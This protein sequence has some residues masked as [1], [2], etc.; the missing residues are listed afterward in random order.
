MTAAE[1]ASLLAEIGLPA[2]AVALIAYVL[3]MP[4]KAQMISG[5]LWTLIAGVFRR[6]DRKAVA[7]RVQGHVNASTRQIL[8]EVPEGIIEGKLKIRWSDAEQAQS[9]LR[10][11]EVVV[12]MRRSKHHEE[13][14]AHALMVY[15]PKA[16]LP[17]ARRYLDKVTMETRLDDREERSRSVGKRSR[18]PRRVL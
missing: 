8:K 5:W 9:I 2:V 17:R 11:G 12:F 3:L 18:R 14:V 6:G 1:V 4:E 10:G 7:L 13:N 16:V 15:L